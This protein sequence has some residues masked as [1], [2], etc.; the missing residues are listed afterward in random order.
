[1]KEF[2]AWG[3]ADAG[4][5]NVV[6]GGLKPYSTSTELKR[7]GLAGTIEFKP[8][9]TITSTIDGFYSN[10]KDDQVKRGI[11]IPLQWGGATLT[12]GTV[13]NGVVTSGTFSNVWNVVRNVVQPRH[14]K[15]YSFGWNT[16]YDGPT[17]WHGFFD[18]SYSKT[19]RYETVFETY[20]GTG[21]NRF[22]FDIRK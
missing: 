18:L 13:T 1:M 21:F 14:A 7:L 15:L 3:Y 12:P 8:T 11:E 17:G 6:I 19:Y 20:A 2:N 22:C 4:G 5:G 9:E 10:F 16:R